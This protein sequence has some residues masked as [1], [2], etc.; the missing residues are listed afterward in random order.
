VTKFGLTIP[1]SY[2]VVVREFNSAYFYV[3]YFTWTCSILPL[4]LNGVLS[5]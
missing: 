5:L 1:P 4:N 3:T 2:E